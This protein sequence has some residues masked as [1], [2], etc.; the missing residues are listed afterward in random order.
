ML[1]RE[2]TCEESLSVENY[3]GRIISLESLLVRVAE[4]EPGAVIS[5]P[6]FGEHSRAIALGNLV[7]SGSMPNSGSVHASLKFP[8]SME[9]CNDA[10]TPNPRDPP[11]QKKL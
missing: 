5:F 7:S 2:V 4:N 11:P 1:H 10:R 6:I 8:S 3:L 9:I